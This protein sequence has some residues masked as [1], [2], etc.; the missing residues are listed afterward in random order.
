MVQQSLLA[1][2]IRAEEMVDGSHSPDRSIQVPVLCVTRFRHPH[3][4][5]ALCDDVEVVRLRRPLLHDDLARQ[6]GLLLQGLGDADALLDGQ[7]G[8]DR[9]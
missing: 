9:D 7:G 4:G 1:E 8:E 6:E 3:D 5:F 2:E